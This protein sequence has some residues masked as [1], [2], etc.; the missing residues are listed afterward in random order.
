MSSDPATTRR[1]LLQTVGATGVAGLLAGCLGT[2]TDSESTDTTTSEPTDTTAAATTESTERAADDR[3]QVV[4]VGPDDDETSFAP[5]VATVDPGTT[6][7]FEWASDNHN[8][9]PTDQPDGTDWQG[10]ETLESEGFEYE[11][12]FE[13]PGRYTYVCEPHQSVGM[14]GVV[15]VGDGGDVDAADAVATDTIEV[16][17]DGENVFAPGTD[18]PVEVTAGEPVTFT[19]QSDNHNVV[20]T[21][22]PDDA[23][24]SGHEPLES[25]G[26][27]T[28][29]TFDVPGRYDFECAPHSALGM[30]GTLFVTEN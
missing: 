9:V 23:D 20:P 18:Q 11:H 17:P 22:Q 7:R 3:T 21:D 14:E 29:F 24:W 10:H 27:E 8:V 28:T 6:V 2:A 26:F 30:T 4:T 25:E 19:W 13:T 16:G 12:V 1:T 5:S 15:E